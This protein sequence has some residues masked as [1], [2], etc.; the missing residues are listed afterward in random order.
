MSG[1]RDFLLTGAT[2]LLGRYVLRDLLAAGHRVT[3]LARDAGPVRAGERIAGLV[4]LWGDRHRAPPP[5]PV[6]LGGDLREPGLGLTAGDRAWLTRRR[7][8]VVHAAADVTLRKSF[9]SDPWE[10]NAEGTRRLLELC[11]TLGVSELHHVSTAFVCGDRTGPVAEHE[12]EAGQGFHNDYERSKFEAERRLRRAHGVRVTVYRPSVIVGDSRTGYTSTYHGPYHFLEAAVRLAE[13]TAG[14]R[15]RLP[16]RLP[17]A[18]EEP[19]N[20]VPVDWVARAIVR[21]AH[22]P[23]CQ[24]RTFHLTAPE[25]VPVR[26]IKEVAERVLVVDGVSFAGPGPLADPS[27]LEELFLDQLREYWPYRHGDPVFD[28]SNA[29][30][31]LPDLPPPRIDRT[32]LERLILFA[33]ADEWGRSRR[34]S[35]RGQ[36]T[37]DCADYVEWFFPDAARRSTLARLPLDLT[38]GLEV[39]GPGGGRWRCRWSGRELAEVRRGPAAGAAVVYRMDRATFDSVV[40]GRESPQAAFFARRIEIEGDLEKALKLA[41][42]FGQFVKECP[43]R[44]RS[45]EVAD[46]ARVG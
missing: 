41:V 13:P 17:F 22:R 10:T 16:L 12:L 15:R 32:T 18:G 29:R 4:A 9:H 39:R 34:R 1:P 35:G 8:V 26:A 46:V 19:R 6:V 28:A 36:G 3:V 5:G 23:K 14:G 37:V 25:P 24:G 7:P 30:A 21:T 43:Y 33:E 45:E 2:G 11:E 44:P 38:F 20:L 40:R 27:P 31:A 42:L